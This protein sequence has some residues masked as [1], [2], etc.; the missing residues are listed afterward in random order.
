[1]HDIRDLAEGKHD[2]HEAKDREK[3][4]A[5][6]PEPTFRSPIAKRTAHCT[7]TDKHRGGY[8]GTEEPANEEAARDGE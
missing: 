5:K 6:H 8:G 3:K 1:M 2:V 7:E 4:T